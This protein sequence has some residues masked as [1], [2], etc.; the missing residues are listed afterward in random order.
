MRIVLICNHADTAYAI[1]QARAFSKGHDVMLILFVRRGNRPVPRIGSVFK[2]IYAELPR[3]YHPGNIIIAFRV[4]IRIIKFNPDILHFHGGFLWLT[5]T[6]PFL[7]RYPI[8]TT[9]H[10]VDP[11]PG[12]VDSQKMRWFFPN[13]LACLFSSRIIVH[14]KA[15]KEKLVLKYQ[16]DPDKVHVVYFGNLF[17]GYQPHIDCSSTESDG[18]VLFFGRILEYKDLGCLIKATPLIC[19]K[20]PD[21]NIVIAG[22]GDYI[23]SHE[24]QI[25]DKKHFTIINHFIPMEQFGLLFRRATI[26]VLPYK[27]ASQSGV[28]PLAYAFSKPVV[29]TNVGSLPEMVEP[30]RTGLVV[31]PQ[32]PMRLAQAI[33]SLLEDRTKAE[34]MGQNA[35]LKIKNELNW[36]KLGRQTLKVYCRAVSRN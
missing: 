14:G 36:E 35:L 29:V 28:I 13:R 10:D 11:H 12:D 24:H 9:I 34:W 23:K 31:P 18:S 30:G 20:I 15:I 3:L 6:L 5:L 1:E 22:Q 27:E 33:I 16:T 26:V 17:A 19:E 2:V 7:M 32:N 8:V 4:A 25:R 21:V